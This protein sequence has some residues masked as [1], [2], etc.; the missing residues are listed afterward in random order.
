[1][2]EWAVTLT[3]GALA[4]RLG[5]AL[6]LGAIVGCERSG[7]RHSAGLRT[8]LLTALAGAVAMLADGYLGFPL[9]LLSAVVVGGAAAVSGKSILFS[10]R[11][12]I[13]GLT[14]AAALWAC[15]LLGVTAG[16]GL[17]T[18][19]LALFV[20]MLA[21]LSGL[22]AA[23][24]L[25]KSRSDH[26]EIHLELQSKPDLQNFVATVRKL[27]LRIDDIEANPAYIG[28]GLSVYTIGLTLRGTEVQT[29]NHA[30]LLEAL[31][32]LPYIRHIEEI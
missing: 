19:T 18:L 1:M 28:S 26:F 21:I 2:G 30:E 15:A 7:K 22:P 8:F 13:K 17:Y 23:E 16:A 10:A 14:T 29:R 24:K 4:L 3:P 32:G 25:L 31:G 11:S 5:L 27:G 6:L 20:C 12:Q 9:P